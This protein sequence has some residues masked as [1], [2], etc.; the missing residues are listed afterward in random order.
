MA[1]EQ[2]YLVEQNSTAQLGRLIKEQT[3]LS[4]SGAVLKYDGRPFYP[5][6]IAD[7]IKKQVR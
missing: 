5:A 7:E 6:E 4:Y 1:C 3:A 2:F